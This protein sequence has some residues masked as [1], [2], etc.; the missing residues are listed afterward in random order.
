MFRDLT[1]GTGVVG[2]IDMS[3]LQCCWNVSEGLAP[4]RVCINFGRCSEVEMS[5]ARARAGWLMCVCPCDQN[6]KHL[7]VLAGLLS[8]EGPVGMR[9]SIAN[10]IRRLIADDHTTQW[11]LSEVPHSLS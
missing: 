8:G 9:S 5:N 3:V 6:D 11:V 2:G 7:G 4:A 10:T 1:A